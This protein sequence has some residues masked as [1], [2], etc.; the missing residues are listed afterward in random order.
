MTVKREPVRISEWLEFSN[1]IF[2][3]L[4]QKKVAERRFEIRFDK[5]C[6]EVKLA[7]SQYEN[8]IETNLSRFDIEIFGLHHQAIDK[9]AEYRAI[10]KNN[11]A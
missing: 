6:L 8:W 3:P 2:S 1:R 10:T 4:Q 11:L 7:L 5:E 9:Q